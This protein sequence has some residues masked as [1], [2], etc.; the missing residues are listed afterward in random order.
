[1][2]LWKSEDAVQCRK[3]PEKWSDSIEINWECS[4]CPRFITVPGLLPGLFLLPRAVKGKDHDA[5]VLT[6]AGAV[7]VDPEAWKS[8]QHIIQRF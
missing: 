1:M 5:L 4:V 7:L 8:L 6:G 2:G 3:R